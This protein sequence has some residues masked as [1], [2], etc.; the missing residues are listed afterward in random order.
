MERLNWLH[1]SR[2]TVTEAMVRNTIPRNFMTSS[3]RPSLHWTC[4]CLFRWPTPGKRRNRPFEVLE[5]DLSGLAT[6]QD[7]QVY[8]LADLAECQSYRQNR[9]CRAF[10]VF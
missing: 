9:H 3:L 5:L 2:I 7:L 1:P 4:D 6:N 10:G 8:L